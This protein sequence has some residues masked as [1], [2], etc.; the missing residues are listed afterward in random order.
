VRKLFLIALTFFIFQA[1]S[2]NAP[3]NGTS[4]HQQQ[5]FRKLSGREVFPKDERWSQA[6]GICN[7]G[8]SCYMNTALKLLWQARRFEKLEEDKVREILD[9]AKKNKNSYKK[10]KEIIKK[11]VKNLREANQ[12][13]EEVRDFIPSVGSLFIDNQTGRTLN[14]SNIKKQWADALMLKSI[15]ETLPDSNLFDAKW[16]AFDDLFVGSY[17]ALLTQLDENEK[18]LHENRDPV[19]SLEERS[20]LASVVLTYL[21]IM[22]ST[23]QGEHTGQQSPAII[24]ERLRN[25]NYD[26]NQDENSTFSSDESIKYY[27]ES[28][29]PLEREKQNTQYAPSLLLTALIIPDV[30]NIKNNSIQISMNEILNHYLE[31]PY[32]P[33]EA[34]NVYFN[35]E[36]ES[37]PKQR[38]MP[39][40]L[41]DSKKKET[42]NTIIIDASNTKK[43]E[44]TDLNKKLINVSIKILP[45][46]IKLSFYPD[47]S[48]DQ[49]NQ[50]N[51]P[52]EWP[53]I[54]DYTIE[55]AGIYYGNGNGGHWIAF[56]KKGNGPTTQWFEHN[57][58]GI[59]KIPETYA[60]EQMRENAIYFLYKK[61]TPS[62]LENE[63]EL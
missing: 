43:I 53:L 23:S 12:P 47:Q 17:N 50:P 35:K 15:N 24:I 6:T 58:S 60:R 51:Q 13:A 31:D 3:Q 56:L 38:H 29:I 14:F 22:A 5:D 16:S 62:A 1:C 45:D 46:N 7:S 21:D 49:Q 55:G 39:L 32:K 33:E 8:V 26:F 54:A 48:P 9:R 44:T 18:A 25:L 10:I 61:I 42:P 63:P 20:L 27:N 40:L 2:S 36:I 28:Y 19:Y 4:N 52:K 41:I 37:D 11:G 57:D 30:D 59:S 34:K